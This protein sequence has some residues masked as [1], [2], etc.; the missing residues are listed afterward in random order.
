MCGYRPPCPRR[1]EA[2]RLVV[3]AALITGKMTAKVLVVGRIVHINNRYLAGRAM[4]GRA[5][6]P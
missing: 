2:R 6:D 5:R 4:V 1:D 3:G